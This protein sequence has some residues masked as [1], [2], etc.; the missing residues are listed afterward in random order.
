MDESVMNYESFDDDEFKKSSWCHGCW[1]RASP[2]G[3]KV[4]FDLEI[5]KRT[6]AIIVG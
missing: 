5:A 4:T 1:S 2:V 6:V 3:H